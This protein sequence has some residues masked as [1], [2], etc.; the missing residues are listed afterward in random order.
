MS[1]NV[2]EPWKHAAV[3]KK[4]T[5]KVTRCMSLF[6]W[7]VQKRQIHRPREQ[8]NGGGGVGGS[9]PGGGVSLWGHQNAPE[10]D[11]GGGRTTLLIP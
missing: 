2:E 3:W 1:Y 6:I 4:P 5:Q 11:S 10:G 7:K 8:S 9:A